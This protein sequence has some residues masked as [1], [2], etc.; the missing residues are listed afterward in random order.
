MAGR[1]QSA[2]HRGG[3]EALILVTIAFARFGERTGNDRLARS[4]DEYTNRRDQS[5][6]NEDR[7][8]SLRKRVLVAVAIALQL[9]LHL[10]VFGALS[11]PR[12]VPAESLVTYAGIVRRSTGPWFFVAESPTGHVL[13]GFTGVKCDSST[14]IL[15][16]RFPM[17]VPGGLKNVSS[18][19]V[20]HDETMARR[21][22]IAG[23]SIG[24]G[25]MRILF[26]QITGTGPHPM[27]CNN[28]L[29]RGANANF[30]IGLVGQPLP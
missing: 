28:S 12:T 16:V 2:Y 1:E 24:H 8:V 18:A 27:S 21:G 4:S 6:H 29:L 14:G 3:R 15:H 5:G 30:W 19:W 26:T 22:I 10:G 17:G 7:P 20:Q 9:T 11:A 25:D 23:P 13:S